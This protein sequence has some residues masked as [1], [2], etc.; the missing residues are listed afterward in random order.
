MD[1]QT[2]EKAVR[3]INE[4]LQNQ[5]KLNKEISSGLVTIGRAISALEDR[6]DKLERKEIEDNE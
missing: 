3:E 6:I 4:I 1:K 2:L 5:S